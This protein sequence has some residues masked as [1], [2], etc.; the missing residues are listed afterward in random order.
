MK[1]TQK[2]LVLLTCWVIANDLSVHAT[3]ASEK[4]IPGFNNESRAGVVITTGNSQT[5][6]YDLSQLDSYEWGANKLGFLGRYLRSTSKGI[7]SARRWSV[8]LRYDRTLS[9]SWSLFL[10]ET[11]EGDFYAGY[12]QRY[13]TDV[14]VKYLLIQSDKNT[15][16]TEIGYRAQRENQVIGLKKNSSFGRLYTEFEHRWN[17]TVS[18]KLWAEYLQNLL[19]G[20]DH[21]INS[22]LSLKA[23]LTSIVSL[24]LAYLVRY[25]NNLPLQVTY[26][27]DST[28][29]AAAIAQF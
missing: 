3:E 21:F 9:S 14:G 15:W 29:T 20:E 12:L 25:R 1:F 24:Q 27:T 4:W 13:N 17:P 28:L 16:F 8:G 26:K 19:H 10:A 18:S 7:E 22:E 2:F 6:T 11:I 5:Q 23:T